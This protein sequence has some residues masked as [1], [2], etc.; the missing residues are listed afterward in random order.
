MAARREE[1][2]ASREKMAAM[3][4]ELVPE[5]DALRAESKAIQAEIEARLAR[6]DANVKSHKA[7]V[8]ANHKNYMARMYYDPETTEAPLE[9]EKPP[10][11][12]T[13]PEATHE[14]D[15]PVEDA[16]VIPVGEPEEEEPTSVDRKRGVAQQREVPKEDAGVNPVKGRKRRRR[17]KKLAAGR[18]GAPNN[19][20][21]GDCGS[22]MLPPAGRFPA[23]QQW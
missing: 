3:R 15:V 2:A 23:V 18:R 1:M 7:K 6:M 16:I 9:E 14:E 4:G 17:C 22:R 10:S 21:R 8:E 13:K 11:V 5:T 12:D 19:L 20:T